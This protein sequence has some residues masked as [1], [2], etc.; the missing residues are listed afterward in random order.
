MSDLKEK[1]SKLSPA[2]RAQLMHKLAEQQTTLR[3]VK[4]RSVLPLS[5][6]QQR[7]WFLNQLEPGGTNYNITRAYRIRGPLA[8]GALRRSFNE[9]IRRHESLRTTFTIY[10]DAPVQVI[11]PEFELEIPL[12]EANDEYTL[13]KLIMTEVNQPFDLNRGPL[14]RA[15]IVRLPDQN[16][17]LLFNQHHIISDGWSLTIFL[18]ELNLLYAAFV[19]GE[20]S[21]LEETSLQY[22]D[23]AVWQQQG[24]MLAQQLDYWKQKLAESPVLELPTDRPRPAV[25]SYR[26]SLYYLKVPPSL[27]HELKQLA[28]REQATL[29]MLLMAV[30]QVLLYRHSNQEDFAVGS[31]IAGRNRPELE[32]IIGFFVNTLVFAPTCAAPPL[33]A[34]F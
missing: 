6:S 21:P 7:L 32:G 16:H 8:I 22:A 20:P 18:K 12:L 9:I 19:K 17:V 34:N 24:T 4:D 10:S 25:Q 2:Q 23:F 31:P 27:T 33:F 1:L 5:F 11:S 15:S 14:I 28:Q 26:G 30:F 13:H 3:V 29:F